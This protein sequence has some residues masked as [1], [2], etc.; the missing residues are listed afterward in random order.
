MDLHHE[1]SSGQKLSN[2]AGVTG[3]LDAG[4]E[5]EQERVPCTT[6]SLQDPLLTVQAAREDMGRNLHGLC[7]DTLTSPLAGWEL[8]ELRR[9]VDGSHVGKASN[10]PKYHSPIYRRAT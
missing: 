8:K 9:Q 6:H 5:R 3:G 1:V 4:K 7:P 10:L 2:K